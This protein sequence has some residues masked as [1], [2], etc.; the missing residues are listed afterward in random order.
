MLVRV[1]TCQSMCIQISFYAGRL[2][3]L[4]VICRPFDQRINALWSHAVINSYA[5]SFSWN[6]FLFVWTTSKCIEMKR[7]IRI[8]TR[9]LVHDRYT[10]HTE[11]ATNFNKIAFFEYRSLVQ[12]YLF[13]AWDLFSSRLTDTFLFLNK[14]NTKQA[15]QTHKV[16]AHYIIMKGQTSNQSKGFVILYQKMWIV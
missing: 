2:N 16:R 8:V 15:S 3:H 12:F 1:Y 4:K 5:K 10:L 7:K 13:W 14:N 6:W 9:L 11:A